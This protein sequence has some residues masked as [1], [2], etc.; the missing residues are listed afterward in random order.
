MFTFLLDRMP[1]FC[2]AQEVEVL[3]RLCHEESLRRVHAGNWT[4][5][6]LNGDGHLVAERRSGG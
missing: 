1:N 6:N 4:D 3:T 5:R 2:T